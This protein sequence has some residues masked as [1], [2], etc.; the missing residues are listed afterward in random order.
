MP[1]LKVKH[2]AIW[3]QFCKIPHIVSA[4]AKQDK[5]VYSVLLVYMSVAV[6]GKAC[7]HKKGYRMLMW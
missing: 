6:D 7:Y 1:N 3:F 5:T 2:Q 4:N